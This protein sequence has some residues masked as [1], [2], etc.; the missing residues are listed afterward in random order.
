[1]TRSYPYGAIARLLFLFSGAAGLGHQL[2]WARM[3]TAGLGHEMPALLAVLSAFMCG[4]A[5]G[6]WGLDRVISRSPSPGGW[7]GVLELLIGTWGILLVFL[8]PTSNSIAIQLIGLQPSPGWHASIAFVLPIL[9]LLPATAAMGATFAAM[10]RLV[11][12]LN[13]GARCVGGLYAVNTFGAVFGILLATWWLMPAFGFRA[14]ALALA[15]LN[16]GCGVGALWLHHRIEPP[17][18]TRGREGRDALRR[19]R[20]P[21]PEERVVPERAPMPSSR[22]LGIAVF[23]TGLLGIGYEVIGLRVLAQVLENTIYTYAA[24]LTVYLL[25]TATGAAWYQRFARTWKFRP[26]LIDLLGA[27]TLT[28][29]LGI[30]IANFAPAIAHAARRELGSTALASLAAELLLATTVFA[31]PTLFMGATFSHLVQHSRRPDGGVGRA[32]ALNAL[33]SALAPFLFGVAFLPALGSKWTWTIIAFGYLA[34]MPRLEGWRWSWLPAPV[35]FLF[36]LPTN[37]RV[38]DLPPGATVAAWREG[39]LGSVAVVIDPNGH[40]VLRVNNRFQMGG[41]ASANLEALHAHVPLLLHPAPQSALI[42]GAGT[43][44]TL[45][46][47]TLHPGLEAEGVELV[48]EIVEL[49]PW[50]EPENQESIR[51][52]NLQ[53]YVADARRFVLAATRPYDVIVADLFHPA[54]DGAGFLYTR[55]H[56]QAVRRRLSSDGLFCQWLP[57]YQLDHPMLRTIVRTFLDVF[58]ETHLWLLQLNVDVPVAGLVG[59]VSTPNYGSR[60]IERRLDH[61]PLESALKE[62][63]IANSLRF[64]GLWLAGPDDLR[65]FAGPG[66][67]N[68]D[69]H[70]LVLFGAPAFSRQPGATSYGRLTDLLE[71]APDNVPS[72]SVDDG[73]GTPATPRDRWQR[74]LAARNRFLQGLILDSQ[75]QSTEATDAFL[76]SA[77]ISADFTTGYAQCLARASLLA[78]AQPDAAREL[79]R[80]LIEAQPAIP[81]AAQLLDRLRLNPPTDAQ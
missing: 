22:R 23:C 68:T 49:M 31:L 17:L 25:G 60:W 61:P 58:P 9:F 13:N 1:M 16:I 80:R 21:C 35:A 73:S 69:D 48:R 20:D 75:N 11:S 64:F 42:L 8:I 33:G 78:A 26:T 66:A 28:C 40:R 34:L 67:F 24:V 37:L 51:H 38:L 15:L 6:A 30:L 65:S 18:A 44:I 50:F 29:T 12:R 57:L 14:A 5:L 53:L 71:L 76:E 81:V 19:V 62:L 55:E 36:L 7:Y 4:L 72:W 59:Y 2:I 56:F 32:V 10:E 47:T 45:G 39:L 70:P 3:F 41:T 54:R 63:S 27:L 43:G 77:R 79:L 74:Y 52:P 46:A